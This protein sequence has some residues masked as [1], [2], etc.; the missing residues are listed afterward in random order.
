MDVAKLTAG[1]RAGVF[2]VLMMPSV[3]CSPNGLKKPEIVMCE[4][5]ALGSMQCLAL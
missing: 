2:S 3:E 5:S 1:E 4:A